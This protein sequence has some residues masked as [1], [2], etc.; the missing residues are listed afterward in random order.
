MTVQYHTEFGQTL[1]RRDGWFDMAV[2]GGGLVIV[3]Y[4]L[5][6]YLPV[7]RRIQVPWQ[8]YVVLPDVVMIPLDKQVTTIDLNAAIPMQVAQANPVTDADGTRQATIF[9]PQGTLATMVMPD[10]TTQ[11]ISTLNVRAT[12]YTVGENGPNTMPG[13]LPPTSG[14]T[15][16]VELSVD[17]AIAAGAKSVQFSQPVSLYVDNFLA[18]PVGETVPAGSYDREKAAWVPEDNGRIIKI[19]S[20]D[21]AGLAVLDVDGSGL[22]ATAQALI[23]LGIS[24][25]E[26]QKL[27][28]LYSAGKVLWRTLVSHFTPWDCNFPYGPPDDAE[29]PDAPDPEMPDEEDEEDPCEKSGSVIECQN[30][31]LGETVSIVGTPFTLNY[32]SDRVPG[33][34][35]ANKMIIPVTGN[36]MPPGVKRVILHVSIAGRQYKMSFS[37]I[38]NQ[39][40][41]FNWN[42]TDSYGRQLRGSSIRVAIGY[43]YSGVYYD[44]QDIEGWERAWA[45]L[46]NCGNISCRLGINRDTREIILWKDFYSYL[47]SLGHWDA[48]A[49]GFGGWTLDIHHAYDTN[50]HSIIRGDGK[51]RT[52]I[53]T[54]RIVTSS[55]KYRFSDGMVLGSDGAL[56]YSSRN[57]VHKQLPGGEIILVAGDGN[58]NFAGY[59]G[60]G[61]LAINSRLNNPTDLAFGTDG[62]LYIADTGNRVIRRINKEGVIETVAGNISSSATN[63]NIQ[64]VQAKLISPRG[65]AV[66]AENNIYIADT[67]DNK[68]RKVS[69]DGIIYTLA[70]TGISGY[71]GDGGMARLA[72]L[73]GPLD[74]EVGARGEVYIADTGNHRIRRITTAGVI[75]TIAGTG[76][77]TDGADGLQAVDAGLSSPH[78]IHFGADGVLYIVDA[79]NNK[80][81]VINRKASIHTVAGGD[82]ATSYNEGS[83]IGVFRIQNPR[84]VALGAD[85]YM[86]ISSKVNVFDQISKVSL[87]L[88][89]FSGSDIVVPSKNGDFIYTLT[90][91][92]NI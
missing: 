41:T 89:G 60:D 30:Q 84:R 52:A 61:G 58:N 83:S 2:N 34:N 36:T 67:S 56:Y 5:A 8:D 17:E 49:S 25:A 50:K 53:N 13:E 91:A 55:I 87:T 64:A 81:K 54:N 42:G 27:A 90:N 48:R 10:N 44:P 76:A 14:Y 63:D 45:R 86:Y 16:A 39:K 43:V 1:T 21:S 7:Q 22:A 82:V 19:L 77:A 72:V 33:S 92:G 46:A 24:D 69:A 26:R 65:I 85:G 29:N 59:L 78:S 38:P 6:G 73:N 75:K 57:S 70:G 40:Y 71:G 23:D 62:S 32:R 66:D 20:I 37:P 79:G 11:P 47:F 12:E 9:F 74:V 3:N 18:F 4:E 31:V 35:K 15:Y 51:K 88:P 80:I 68:I 28:E